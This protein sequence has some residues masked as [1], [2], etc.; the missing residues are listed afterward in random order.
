MPTRYAISGI[1]TLYSE[2]KHLFYAN[3]RY[4]NHMLDT[5]KIDLVVMNREPHQCYDYVL[6]ALR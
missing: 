2:R 6:W 4:W 1:G 3:L 5:E